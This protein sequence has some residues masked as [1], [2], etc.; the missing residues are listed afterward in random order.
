LP[1]LD[2][3]QVKMVGCIPIIAA[4]V[5]GP[6]QPQ[7]LILSGHPF[8][9]AV[10]G[11]QADSGKFFSNQGVDLI[12]GRMRGNFSNFFQNDQ[13]LFGGPGFLFLGFHTFF[14]NNNYGFIPVQASAPPD[15]EMISPVK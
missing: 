3:P 11:P 10:D 15:T 5:A 9:V 2:A 13:T 4:L 7:D 6:I 12:S 8:Q 14:P 1:A